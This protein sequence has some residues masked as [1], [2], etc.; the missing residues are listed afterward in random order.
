MKELKIHTPEVT[1][2]HA[3]KPIKK[4]LKHVGSVR[5]Q[6]GQIMWE[7]DLSTRIIKAAEYEEVVAVFNP[8][9]NS[10]IQKKI[11]TKE[12]HI[13]APAINAKNAD[14]KFFK[15]LGLRYPK[16]FKPKAK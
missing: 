4:E 3:V 5:L 6:N 13:Y 7:M 9:D 2:Q 14:K 16:N 11:I 10:K 1:E 15:L 8:T 12:N